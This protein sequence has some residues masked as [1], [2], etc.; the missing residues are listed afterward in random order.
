MSDDQTERL[1]DCTR[2]Q[3]DTDTH[4]RV[5]VLDKMIRWC[6][7]SYRFSNGFKLTHKRKKANECCSGSHG[8]FWRQAQPLVRE[9]TLQLKLVSVV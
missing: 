1:Q 2:L 4:T 7:D 6:T 8:D 5:H 3:V 9:L